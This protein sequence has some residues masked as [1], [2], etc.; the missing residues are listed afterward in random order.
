LF[1]AAA[2]QRSARLLVNIKAFCEERL[3]GPYEPQVIDIHQQPE[4][5]GRDRLEAGGNAY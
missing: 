3:P 5:L 1:I 2:N 4:L